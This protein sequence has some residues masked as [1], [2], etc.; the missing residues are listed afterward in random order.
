MRIYRLSLDHS[1]VGVE[2]VRADCGL[3]IGRRQTS[4]AVR[5]FVDTANGRLDFSVG[6]FFKKQIIESHK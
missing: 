5:A 1:R 6:H 4:T 3:A 2:G